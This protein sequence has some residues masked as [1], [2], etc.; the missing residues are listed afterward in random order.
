[1][2]ADN[3]TVLATLMLSRRV[4]T[5]LKASSGSIQLFD[6]HSNIRVRSVCGVASLLAI[7]NNMLGGGWGMLGARNLVGCRMWL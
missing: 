5:V 6:C 4:L 2:G 7:K 3:R 1:M